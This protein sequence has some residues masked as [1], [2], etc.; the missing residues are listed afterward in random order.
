MFRDLP[1]YRQSLKRPREDDNNSRR[2]SNSDGTSVLQ[3]APAPPPIASSS[4]T[5]V[6]D[7]GPI[8]DPSFYLPM[9]SNELG[10][11]TLPGDYHTSYLN[12]VPVSSDWASFNTLNPNF[13]AEDQP[14]VGAQESA[15]MNRYADEYLSLLYGS[16][17]TFVFILPMLTFL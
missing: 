11:Q 9:Y 14:M 10:N 13:A 7:I 3:P 17:I 6:P 2:P 12:N 8:N 15:F 5:F 1:S 4:S 16:V